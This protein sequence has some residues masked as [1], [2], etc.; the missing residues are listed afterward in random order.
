MNEGFPDNG[1]KEHEPS[2]D[3]KES[4]GSIN[5]DRNLPFEAGIEFNPEHLYRMIGE[6][7]F[8]DFLQEGR[9]RPAE[10]T[11]QEYQKSYYHKGHPLKRY[12]VTGTNYFI[13][14]R[15]EE[16]L[17]ETQQGSYPYSSRDITKD[18]EIRIYKVSEDGTAE[19]V[20]DSFRQ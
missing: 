8:Q 13:E 5:I 19:L 18:D 3:K 7:G 10:N 2:R 20:F 12:A 4:L 9:I 17:F 16:G 11:K 1:Q 14:A 15:P 6:S